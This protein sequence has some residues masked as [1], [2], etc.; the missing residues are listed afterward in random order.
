LHA[1]H[2]ALDRAS[3]FLRGGSAKAAFAYATAFALTFASTGGVVLLVGAAR[4]VGQPAL[5]E[6]EARRFALSASGLM[7]CA[8]IEAAVLVTVALG[9]SRSRG[10]TVDVLRLGASRASGLG[11]AAT[12]LGLVGLT[13]AGGAVIELIQSHASRDYSISDTVAIALEG[14]T[15]W[16]LVLALVA[17]GLVPAFAEEVF[18]RG[19]LQTKLVHQWGR[20]PAIV[21]SATAFGF[22]HFDLAQGAVGFIAGLLLGWAAERLGSIRP[23]IAAHATNNALFVALAAMS[24]GWATS[25]QVQPWVLACGAVAL[26]A[27]IIALASPAAL[28]IPSEHSS[29]PLSEDTRGP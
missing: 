16:R 7:T 20:A 6:R 9:A 24:P 2:L 11:S 5:I 12:A 18:F 28:W 15:R 19:F 21:A 17:V 23:C 14:A 1:I 26:A 22:F 13:A 8:F 25:L 29:R 4:A 3:R 10:A 27:A